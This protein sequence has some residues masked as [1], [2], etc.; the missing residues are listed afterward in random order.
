VNS[1]ALRTDP[2]RTKSCVR[3]LWD[4][5]PLLIIPKNPV[6]KERLTFWSFSTLVKTKDG[7]TPKLLLVAREK[8]IADSI[9]IHSRRRSLI[10]FVCC[11]I[12]QPLGLIR[13]PRP[14]PPAKRRTTTTTT[15]RRGG[16]LQRRRQANQKH[17]MVRCFSGRGKGFSLTH[18]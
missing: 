5:Q 8:A 17:T 7:Q 3:A 14:L 10:R 4:W 13:V 15:S 2:Y 1:P 9:P 11:S 6:G 12:H 16:L 18:T